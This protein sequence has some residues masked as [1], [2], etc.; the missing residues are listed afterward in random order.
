MSEGPRISEL[1]REPLRE[2][3]PIIIIEPQGKKHFL[4]LRSGDKFHHTRLGH[5]THDAIIGSPPGTLLRSDL[6]L[7]AICLRLTFED[8]I[9][10][11]LRR[12]TSIIHPKDLATLLVRGDLFPG[13]RVLE[14]GIGSGATAVTLLRYLAPSGELNSYE[15]RE[16]FVELALENIELAH[17]LYGDP[18][19][20][21]IVRVRDI[22][23]EGIEEDDLDTVVLDVPEPH[24]VAPSALEALRPGG[25]LLCWLPTVTQIYLLVRELQQEPRWSV[26][27]TRETM[28][29]NWQVAKNAMRPYHR[30][31][32]HTGFWIRARKVERAIGTG[33]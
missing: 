9:L 4:R 1:L 17:E 7:D 12:R 31:I 10:K 23:E 5:V 14:A 20:K 8:F 24:R 22:Y 33:E 21:H 27:E 18:G 11:E 29:R 3:E 15:R 25:T 13:A 28:E 32:G 19:T 30:M 16:E 26:V 2:G 6:G